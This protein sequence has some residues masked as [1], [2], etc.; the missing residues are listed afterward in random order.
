MSKLI[1]LIRVFITLGLLQFGF[2]H[3]Y[4]QIQKEG[5]FIAVGIKNDQDFI[6]YFNNFKKLVN[7][8]DSVGLEKI[9]RSSYPH[10]I[11][12]RDR[13]DSDYTGIVVRIKNKTL[14]FKYYS[15]MFNTRMRKMISQQEIKD[16]SI[17]H[18][19]VML[20][21]GQVWW[22]YEKKKNIIFTASISNRNAIF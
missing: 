2:I 1:I 9:M 18:I 15:R 12:K 5:R 3:T 16:L 7:D 20:G 11:F 21:N 4:A 19:G 10:L 14:F 6:A 13:P 17:T 22:G 8:N